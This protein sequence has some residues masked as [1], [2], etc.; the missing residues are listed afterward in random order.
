MTDINIK[1]RGDNSSP[2]RTVGWFSAGAASA[3]ACALA[4]PDVIAYCETG[5]EHSDNQRFIQDCEA[6][7]GWAVKRLKS[8][9]YS[10]TWDVWEKN[11]YLSGVA[12][13]PCTRE[14]KVKPRLAFQR[15]DDVHVFGYTADAGDVARADAMREHYPEMTIEVPL[16]DRG[17]TKA[18]CLAMLQKTGI[19]EPITYALGFPNANCLLCVKAT[20]PRYWSLGRKHFPE[21]FERMAILSRKMN[22]K[23]SRIDGERVF[24]DEIPDDYPTT[25]P[26][27]P[28]CDILCHLAEQELAL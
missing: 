13:A 8:E 16:I 2:P 20:S 7:Y 26:I 6:H 9:K 27:A 28:E 24:I 10:D 1:S 14:L 15:P 21:H 25:D 11:K 17:V 22:V 12:G 23:L 4:K 19:A 5:S 3:I 18:A